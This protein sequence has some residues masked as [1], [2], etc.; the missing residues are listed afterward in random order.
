MTQIDW[1]QAL[2]DDIDD[3][4]ALRSPSAAVAAGQ[5]ALRRRR[6]LRAGLG[7]TALVL[8]ATVGTGA[9]GSTDRETPVEFANPSATHHR[10]TPASTD[11]RVDPR[12][13]DAGV[14]FD[15]R[16][17]LTR[18]SERVVVGGAYT[19]VLSTDGSGYWDKTAAVETVV[20]GVTT[21]HVVRWKAGG[22]RSGEGVDA[23]P[24]MDFDEWVARLATQ[25]WLLTGR[26]PQ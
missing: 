22:E 6:L 8:A 12:F 7:G 23:R 11:L 21:W 25:T 14:S 1:G 18:G 15:G 26:E 13:G 24:D 17:R 4:P 9:L 2:E 3:G 10:A 16:G 20:D 5:R 19:D